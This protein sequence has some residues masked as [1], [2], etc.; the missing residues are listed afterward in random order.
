MRLLQNLVIT[1][2]V[3]FFESLFLSWKTFFIGSDYVCH[4]KL[5]VRKCLSSATFTILIYR[6]PVCT[7]LISC[8]YHWNRWWLGCNNMRKY[9]EWTVLQNYQHH[10][11]IKES[12]RRSFIFIFRLNI[13]LHNSY[14][15]DEIVTEIK[16]W[17]QKLPDD[18]VKIYSRV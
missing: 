15:A 8:H 10:K 7:P 16:E 17:K 18:Y 12:K 1:D 11:G 9:G 5:F 6:S 4:Q 2:N 3:R 14:H 13:V